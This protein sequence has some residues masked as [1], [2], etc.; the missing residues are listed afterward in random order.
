MTNKKTKSTA[1]TSSPKTETAEVTATEEVVI[2][3]TDAADNK[4]GEVFG[5]PRKR[6]KRR[7]VY[8]RVR[9]AQIPDEVYEHFAKDDYYPRLV[10]WSIHGD[11]DY[12]YLNR[13]LQE[14]YEFIT[15]DELPASYLQGLRIKDTSIVNGMVT[16]GADLC[17]MKVDMDLRE[18]RK[19]Y[20]HDLAHKQVEAVDVHVERNG[21]RNRSKTQVMMREPSFK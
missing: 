13:R 15:K 4:D 12:G 11:I 14:G 20:Y 19:D 21:L 9:E 5:G 6:V 8:E 1:T 10:R 16:N 18:S 2:N 17:L 7:K 3:T